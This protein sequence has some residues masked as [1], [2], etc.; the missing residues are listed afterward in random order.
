MRLQ[1]RLIVAAFHGGRGSKSFALIKIANSAGASTEE[2][3]E[4]DGE[5]GDQGQEAREGDGEVGVTH[6]GT[7]SSQ[8]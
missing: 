3:A 6:H 2:A 4:R 7:E 1:P 5:R 8:R